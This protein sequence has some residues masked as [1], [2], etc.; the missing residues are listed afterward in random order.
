[1][2]FTL[3]T[4]DR[5]RLVQLFYAN[6]QSCSVVQR[7][8]SSEKNIKRKSDQPSVQLI[9]H[10]IEDFQK[11][12]CISTEH[13]RH[14]HSSSSAIR[15]SIDNAFDE[16]QSAGIPP[17]IRKVSE[18]SGA[19]TGTVHKRLRKELMLYPYKVTLGQPL[20]VDH[21]ARRLFFCE[22]ML[23]EINRDAT[24]LS[25]IIWS[26]E[27]SFHLDGWVNRQNLR[28]W[29]TEKPSN[30]VEE[31]TLSPKVNVW[32]AISSSSF[33]GPYFFEHEGSTATIN[34][35]RYLTL[36]R[37]FLLPQLQQM[38]RFHRLIFQQDGAPPH[39]SHAVIQFLTDAFSH[40]KIISRG[41][42]RGWPAQSP[43]LTPLD[44]WL[45]SFLKEKVYPGGNRPLNKEDLKQRIENA[46]HDLSVTHL[47]AAVENVHYRLEA[48]IA[49][50][51]GHFE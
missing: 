48:C 21:K 12:G 25:R 27:C 32:V 17:S 1:M 51:G 34:S 44:F 41:F 8:F 36:L 5:I 28:F 30:V 9:H 26:D 45:W 22:W 20:S 43:D 23:H 49:H 14:N 7:K 3:S 10:I 19:S 4:N 39:V 31:S 46:V 16:L 15:D 47:Q 50:E 42:P 33:I 6:E 13:Y 2:S 40:Q 29:G 11:T 35:E 18:L 38:P 24:F 37:D